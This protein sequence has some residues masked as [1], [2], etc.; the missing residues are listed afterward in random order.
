LLCCSEADG[1]LPPGTNTAAA[2]PLF[3]PLTGTTCVFSRSVG[4]RAEITYQRWVWARDALSCRQEA[5][6]LCPRASL[7]CCICRV[8]LHLITG[9]KQ[10]LSSSGKKLICRAT[11]DR[12]FP[13]RRGW[14]QFVLDGWD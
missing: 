8:Q 4:V 14:G 9:C 2:G 6:R 12:S 3:S 1:K 5:M 13:S 10:T 7:R 11:G